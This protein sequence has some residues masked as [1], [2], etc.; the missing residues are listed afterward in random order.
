MNEIKENSPG[1]DFWSLLYEHE[2]SLSLTCHPNF[3]TPTVSDTQTYW[4]GFCL[5]VCL[6]FSVG[7]S[8]QEFQDVHRYIYKI[9]FPP[10]HPY[11]NQSNQ[12]YSASP[13]CFLPWIS[14][15]TYSRT[16]LT[17]TML[18]TGFLNASWKLTASWCWE[19]PTPHQG[20]SLLLQGSLH[21]LSD[22]HAVPFFFSLWYF[23][24]P[25]RKLHSLQ[26]D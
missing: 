23:P 9:L 21:L 24:N 1:L 10:F 19:K 17:D 3:S 5:G 20:K 8:F 7:F 15:S 22:Y 14:I 6:L 16:C 13:S 2:S 4:D 26:L 11:F 12:M 18:D 25:G